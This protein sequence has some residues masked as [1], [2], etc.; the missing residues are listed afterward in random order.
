E[1]EG[2]NTP[3]PELAAIMWPQDPHAEEWLRTAKKIAINASSTAADASSTEQIDGAPLSEWNASVNLH[4]DL[5][6]ENHGYFNTIYQMVPHLL[7]GDAAVMDAQAGRPI[8][9][10]FS[11]RT[12]KIY[13]QILGPMVTGDGD[14]LAP[15]GQDWTSKDYQH[16]DYLAIMATRF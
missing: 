15:A 10:A 14:I 16:L 1:D 3:T 8:P 11:F 4:P 5:T 9:Q 12:E 2:W 6:L 13:D 7:I